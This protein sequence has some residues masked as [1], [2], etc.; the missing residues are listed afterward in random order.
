MSNRMRNLH[1]HKLTTFRQTD[2]AMHEYI[3]KCSYLVEHAYTLTP[4]DPANMILGSNFIEGIMN[5][6]IKNKLRSC[7]ISNLQD[8]FKFTLKED[9][10]QKIRALDFEIKTDIKT[11]TIAHGDIQAIKG[12]SCHK[13]GNEG[14]SIKDCPLHQINPIQ[15]LNPTPNHKHSYIPHSRSN[16]NNTDMLTPITKT[17]NYLFSAIKTAIHNKHNLP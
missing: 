13:C 3:S 10:K 2:L 17:L 6:Y 9:Q 1:M 11:D 12:S 16:S 4:T 8:I 14:H 15:H 5:P 7:K